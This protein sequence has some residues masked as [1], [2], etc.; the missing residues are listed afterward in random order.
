MPGHP[1]SPDRS[2]LVPSFDLGGLI[3]EFAPEL[4]GEVVSMLLGH[5][6]VQGHWRRRPRPDVV[7]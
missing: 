5:L 3:E 7:S 2:Q 6:E 1:D 4:P